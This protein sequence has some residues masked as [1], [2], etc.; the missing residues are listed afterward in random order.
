MRTGA[1]S[2]RELSLTVAPVARWCGSKAAGVTRIRGLCGLL[3]LALA[4]ADCVLPEEEPAGFYWTGEW[5]FELV[6]LRKHLRKAE[7][8]VGWFINPQSGKEAAMRYWRVKPN[9]A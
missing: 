5:S 1:L 9:A 4:E 7:A 3:K 8:V 2:S 6:E